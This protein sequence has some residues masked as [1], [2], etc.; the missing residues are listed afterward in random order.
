M[1]SL[2]CRYGDKVPSANVSKLF[3]IVWILIGLVIMGILSGA[4]TSAITMFVIKD[5]ITLYGAKVQIIA[6]NKYTTL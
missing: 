2:Y 4:L 3:A 5:A 6:F 1:V